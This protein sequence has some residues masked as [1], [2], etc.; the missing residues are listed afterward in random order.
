MF[1]TPAIVSI[2]RLPGLAARTEYGSEKAKCSK[3][4]GDKSSRLSSAE[5][6]KEKDHTRTHAIREGGI[7]EENMK[8]ESLC[9]FRVSSAP[10]QRRLFIA[11]QAADI[12]DKRGGHVLLATW[13]GQSGS[14]QQRHPA[15]DAEERVGRYFKSICITVGSSAETNGHHS[16]PRGDE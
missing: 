6:D 3:F 11:I 14:P 13:T 9:R 1:G 2:L 12:S 7:R 5:G 16:G 10:I 15:F 4:E 8:G